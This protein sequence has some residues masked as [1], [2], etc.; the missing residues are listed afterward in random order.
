[1]QSP[2]HTP[3]AHADCGGQIMP[4][5]PQLFESQSKSAPLQPLSALQAPPSQYGVLP[6]QT[7]PQA[8][9]LFASELTNVQV[10]PQAI[11]PATHQWMHCP[12]THAACALGPG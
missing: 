6:P 12:P 4:Q 9:Q 3:Q 8:P 10:S 11:A 2:S 5:P 7:L 1:M